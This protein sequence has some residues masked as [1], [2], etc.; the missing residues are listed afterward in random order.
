VSGY[1]T[2]TAAISG[3]AT[4]NVNSTGLIDFRT[5]GSGTTGNL[6][7][8]S[9]TT[10]GTVFTAP[11]AAGFVDNISFTLPTGLGYENNANFRFA[12]VGAFDPAYLGSSGTNGYV[13]SFTGQDSLNTI[14]GYNRSSGSGGS[15]R[16]DL[17]TVTAV[18]EPAT[19]AMVGTAALIG[20]TAAWRRRRRRR[21]AA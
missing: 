1:N 15:L 18:P 11:L 3:T 2:G 6:L 12:I 14:D 13:S 5:I 4:V 16:L 20:G 21:L 9:V 8:P 19:I 17:V 7:T 10:T